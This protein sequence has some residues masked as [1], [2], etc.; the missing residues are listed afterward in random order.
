MGGHSVSTA[1]SEGS[2]SSTGQHTVSFTRHTLC[3]VEE[4]IDEAGGAHHMIQRDM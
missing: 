4:R 3:V 1:G 2:A